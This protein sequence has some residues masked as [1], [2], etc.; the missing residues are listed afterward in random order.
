MENK[1][2]FFLSLVAVTISLLCILPAEVYAESQGQIE[3]TFD[4]EN[5]SEDVSDSELPENA[6]QALQAAKK[7]IEKTGVSQVGLFEIL[8]EVD[9]YSQEAADYAVKQLAPKTDWNAQAVK[10]AKVYLE[11]TDYSRAEILFNLEETNRFTK[12]QAIYAVNQ[13]YPDANWNER[14]LTAAENYLG[15]TH[16]S[17]KGLLEQLEEVYMYT[18]E[19]AN[20]AIAH[21]DRYTDWKE[22]ARKAADKYVKTINISQE[23]LV[24]KL[25]DQDLFPAEDVDLAVCITFDLK[26]KDNPFSDIDLSET[27]YETIMS[28]YSSGVIKGYDDGT[29]KSSE[30]LKRQHIVRFL[31]R[32]LRLDHEGLKTSFED[33]K[34]HSA[35]S[36]IAAAV[37]HGI[38]EGYPDGS[39]KPDKNITRAELALMISRAYGLK[40][41]NEKIINFDDVDKNQFGYDAIQ[42]LA[43]NDVVSGY[44]D[45]RFGPSQNATRGEFSKFL[46]NAE[47]KMNKSV[48]VIIEAKKWIGARGGSSMHKNMVDG[49][50][51]IKPFPRGYKVKYEDD[52]CNIFVTHIFD[53]YKASHLTGRECGVE[54]HIEIF[55]SK[56]IWIEDG[57]ITPK[58]ADLITYNWNQTTQPNTGWADHIGIVENVK[59][60]Q[61]TVIEGNVENVVQR[62]IISVGHGYIRG[63]ARPKYEKIIEVK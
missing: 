1:L 26:I 20:Y 49:Y 59:G 34:E 10:A 39:F 47:H 41:N 28:L 14:A 30:N 32:S 63:Y 15:S 58:K 60:N 51:A 8:V 12:D 22:Q 40:I 53:K 62:R 46:V 7:H 35:S 37:E 27:H 13:D 6:E 24:R 21:V 19:E 52:W 50:N 5:F 2:R 55:K 23:G 16:C 33:S 43:S 3:L 4:E 44:G 29:F 54:R 56:G 17:R 42:A 48:A 31:V 25:V 11:L 36:Y 61:I 45:G 18:P 38:I 9:K 57:T